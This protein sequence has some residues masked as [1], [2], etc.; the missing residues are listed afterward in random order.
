VRLSETAVC[1]S[2]NV[3]ALMRLSLFIIS[4]AYFL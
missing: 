4:V 3:H 2:E 1:A